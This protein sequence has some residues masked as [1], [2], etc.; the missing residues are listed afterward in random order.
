MTNKPR[1]FW[2]YMGEIDDIVFTKPTY[3]KNQDKYI[4]VIEAAPVLEKIARL[5]RES[6]DSIRHAINMI[7]KIDCEKRTKTESDV[8]YHLLGSIL[9]LESILQGD[10]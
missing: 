8:L 7:D 4:H 9:E 2:I 10:K 3:L 1:E 5:E 6:I